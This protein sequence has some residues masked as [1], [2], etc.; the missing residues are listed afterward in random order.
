V[1]KARAVAEPRTTPHRTPS[2]GGRSKAGDKEAR[3]FNA[4]LS[5]YLRPRLTEAHV[6]GNRCYDLNRLLTYAAEGMIL[7]GLSQHRASGLIGM[8]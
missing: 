7:R 5:C 2:A 4:R 8:T 3:C 6:T 1:A